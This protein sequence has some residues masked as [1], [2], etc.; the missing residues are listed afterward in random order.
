MRERALKRPLLPSRSLRAIYPAGIIFGSVT[1]NPY[2]EILLKAIVAASATYFL[3]R[4]AV[5]VVSAAYAAV[6]YGIG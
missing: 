2:S 5:D 3:V 4:I 6:A 1:M